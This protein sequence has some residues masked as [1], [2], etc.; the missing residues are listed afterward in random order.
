[1]I[2]RA[3]RT[4]PNFRRKTLL[5]AAFH[6][7][8][9]IVAGL[10][11]V[12]E[13][14]PI[15][16]Q[17]RYLVPYL[18]LV[19]PIVECVLVST[20]FGFVLSLKHARN[21]IDDNQ[22]NERSFK[23][24][25][26]SWIRRMYRSDRHARRDW[27]ENLDETQGQD[28]DKDQNPDKE[29]NWLKNRRDAEYLRSIRATWHCRDF[30]EPDSFHAAKELGEL[31]RSVRFLHLKKKEQDRVKVEDFCGKYARDRGAGPVIVFSK[32]SAQSGTICVPVAPLTFRLY[33]PG[34]PLLL[35]SSAF[36]G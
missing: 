8:A 3:K 26:I 15:D 30:I 21:E 7:L 10:A 34:R 6:F 32:R 17:P 36:Q 35:C 12:K 25:L 16:F 22:H 27:D 11:I 4:A 5:V 18:K 29:R 2:E 24:A 33:V 20:A 28:V 14:H 19:P 13:L 9:T 1:M 23:R 31:S